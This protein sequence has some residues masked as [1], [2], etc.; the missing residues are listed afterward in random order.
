MRELAWLHRSLAIQVTPNGLVERVFRS[1]E[2]EVTAYGIRSRRDLEELGPLADQVGSK[3][4][5]TDPATVRSAV[6]VCSIAH[7]PNRRARV[8]RSRAP[9]RRLLSVP[10]REEL[11]LDVR[12]DIV[13]DTRDSVEHAIPD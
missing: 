3:I 1:R 6:A 5:V 12:A 9:V 4:E 13:S 7:P 8:G 10:D 2:H 11:E